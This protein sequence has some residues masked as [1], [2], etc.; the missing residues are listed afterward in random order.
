M[1]PTHLPPKVTVIIPNWNTESWLT[2]CL[3]GLRMQSYRE[4]RVILVDNG[5]TDNSLTLVRENYPEVEILAFA[6]NRGFAPAVNAGIRQ[7]SSEY[8]ALLNV[9]TIPQP[10]WLGSR[11]EVIEQSPPEVGAVTSKILSLDNPD[12]IDDAGNTLSWYGSANKRGL[13]ESAINYPELEEV[14]SI[15]GAASLYRRS[16]LENSGFF[17]EYFISYLE[18]IDLG[19]RGRLLGYRYLYVPTAKVLHQWRGAGIPRPKYIFLSTRNRLALL[20]KNIPWSLILRHFHTLLFGQFYFLLVYKKPF[21]SLAGVGSFLLAL[22]RILRQRREIQKRKRISNQTLDSMLCHCLDEPSL[23]E[24]TRRKLVR[25]A[26]KIFN[27]DFKVIR[28][29]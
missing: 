10:D 5:S 23:K 12:I 4:F 17:D 6:E 27:V 15:S 28:V 3:E 16:F 22:P 26:R 1:N 9:D 29:V 19:L 18:D 25:F 20:G 24:L 14:F 13:G 11:V 21:Y 8:I 7:A 2:G